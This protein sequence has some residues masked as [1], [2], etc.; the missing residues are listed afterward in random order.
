MHKN[1]KHLIK[2]S[3]ELFSL[4]YIDKLSKD[5]IIDILENLKSDQEFRNETKSSS[6]SRHRLTKKMAISERYFNEN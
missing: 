5:Q 4:D 3:K 2:V 1:L 6:S